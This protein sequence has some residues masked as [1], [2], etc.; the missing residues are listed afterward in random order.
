MPRQPHQHR[1]VLLGRRRMR[2]NGCRE[3]TNCGQ[4][5]F[6]LR[7]VMDKKGDSRFWST[8]AAANRRR[9]TASFAA[10]DFSR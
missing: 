9:K 4:V 10:Q 8:A 2:P 1:D 3:T 6:C 5:P 7:I